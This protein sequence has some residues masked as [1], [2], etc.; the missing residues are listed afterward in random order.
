MLK[1]KTNF[2]LNFFDSIHYCIFYIYI[3]RDLFD[4]YKTLLFCS[5]KARERFGIKNEYFFS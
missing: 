3:Y 1:Y 4:W 2:T 5:A